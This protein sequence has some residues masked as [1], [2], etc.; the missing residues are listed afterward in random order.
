MPLRIVKGDIVFYPTAEDGPIASSSASASGGPITVISGEHKRCLAFG[1]ILGGLI[2]VLREGPGDGS[3]AGPASTSRDAKRKAAAAGKKGAKGGKTAAGTPVS[4]T[5]KR[6]LS[7]C[8]FD[9]ATASVQFLTHVSVDGWTSLVVCP[10]SPLV[11]LSDYDTAHSEVLEWQ[12]ASKTLR[13]VWEGRGSCPHIVN[14]GRD[15]LLLLYSARKFSLC[16]GKTMAETAECS[17]RSRDLDIS[18]VLFCNSYAFVVYE[19]G[20]CSIFEV[21]E[22]SV[23]RVLDL[24]KVLNGKRPTGV[25]TVDDTGAIIVYSSDSSEVCFLNPMS[26][27][28]KNTFEKSMDSKALFRS[29]IAAANLERSKMGGTIRVEASD[30]EEGGSRKKS[31]KKDPDEKAERSKEKKGGKGRDAEAATA[32]AGGNNARTDEA[33][34]ESGGIGLVTLAAVAVACMAVTATVVIKVASK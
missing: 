6:T 28:N 27:G 2:V 32:P 20:G 22:D 4:S 1:S 30:D 10:S 12:S 14:E 25:T 18:D 26:V 31:G 19:N 11:V 21:S 33:D 34:G 8:T 9:A 29:N 3:I 7:V 5:E 13:R 17:A 15:V 23:R 24:G 16:V